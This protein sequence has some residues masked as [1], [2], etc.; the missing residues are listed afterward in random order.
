MTYS[1]NPIYRELQ[2]MHE[3]IEDYDCGICGQ[4]VFGDWEAVGRPHDCRLDQKRAFDEL[5]DL[6]TGQKLD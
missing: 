1:E 2:K 3:S 6:T 4:H 5:R